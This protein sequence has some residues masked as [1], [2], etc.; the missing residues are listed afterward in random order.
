MAP[1]VTIEGWSLE[2]HRVSHGSELI[3]FTSR[4]VFA[5]FYYS[6]ER[7][8]ELVVSTLAGNLRCP[9][10]TPPNAEN[11]QNRMIPIRPPKCKR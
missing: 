11:A 6:V 10:L 9:D 5:Y 2:M 8:R 3:N 1:S 7:S 4:I